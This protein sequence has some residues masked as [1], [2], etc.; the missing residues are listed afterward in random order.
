MGIPVVAI[1]VPTVVD[2][3][4]LAF[5]LLDIDDERMGV[6]LSKAVSPQGRSMVVTPKEVDLLIDRAAHLISLSVNMAL[7]PDLD[8]D[9]LLDLL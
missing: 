9:D 4:T 5:D 6:E 1:G 7:Q 3:L 8:T 2:A